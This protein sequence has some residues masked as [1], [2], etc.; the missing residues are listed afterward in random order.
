MRRHT[1]AEYLDERVPGV[2][3]Q[4]FA[5]GIGVTPEWLQKQYVKNRLLV[6]LLIAGYRKEVRGLD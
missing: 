4:G 6:R 5:R 3:L 1:L 2:T